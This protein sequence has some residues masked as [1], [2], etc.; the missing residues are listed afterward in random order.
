MK[1]DPR[2]PLRAA[3][4]LILVACT[5][6]PLAAA[7]DGIDRDAMADV[8]SRMMEAMGF[9]GETSRSSALKSLPRGAMGAPFGAPAW[10]PPLGAPSGVPGLGSSWAPSSRPGAGFGM[11]EMMEHFADEGSRASDWWSWAAGPLEGVWES[12]DGGLLIVQGERY[13]LYQ[14]GAGYADGT[15]RLGGGWLTLRHQSRGIEH[16]FEIAVQGER[17]ALRSE[18][19][20]L[21]VYRRLR[22]NRQDPP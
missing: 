1:I 17:L 9:L 15:L 21:F 2:M 8:M 3:A 11:D 14:P 7:E 20:Q 4:T 16:R 22:L 19:G 13:R 5:I 6:A 10:P 12:P 18:S